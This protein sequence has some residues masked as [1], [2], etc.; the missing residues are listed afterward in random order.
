MVDFRITWILWH[1]VMRSIFCRSEL[2]SR[3]I[4]YA[5][6]SKITQMSPR[7]GSKYRMRLFFTQMPPLWGFRKRSRLGNL[8]S[9]GVGFP[10]LLE[11]KLIS[12]I[13]HKCFYQLLD[14]SGIYTI[15]LRNSSSRDAPAIRIRSS[16]TTRIGALRSIVITPGIERPSAKWSA[17]CRG[18]LLRLFVT[19]MK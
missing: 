2:R 5:Y 8:A 13:H 18:I 6:L 17:R 19:K 16:R 1:N 10:L 11:C 9:E 7:W 14:L 15:R 3:Y 12:I 4:I